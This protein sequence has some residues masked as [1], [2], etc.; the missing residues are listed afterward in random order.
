M[1]WYIQ[2][3][4]GDRWWHILLEHGCNHGGHHGNDGW[5]L[6]GHGDERFR[7][8]SHGLENLDGEC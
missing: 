8:Y 2:Y 7:L 6:H 5:H 3:L 1:R 4:H